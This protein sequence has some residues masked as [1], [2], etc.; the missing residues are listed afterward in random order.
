MRALSLVTTPLED[1]LLPRMDASE[2]ADRIKAMRKQ[3]QTTYSCSDYLK[4]NENVSE[5]RRN[6]S[7][8]NAV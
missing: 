1:A 8:K 4:D 3:E 5:K 2:V 6:Q 7:M